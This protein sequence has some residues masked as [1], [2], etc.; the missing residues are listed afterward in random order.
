MPEGTGMDG[1]PVETP[2]D[3]ASDLTSGTVTAH[4]PVVEVAEDLP[5][6][7]ARDVTDHGRAG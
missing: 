2:G 7:L 6:E 5:R 4:E 1:V 3:G